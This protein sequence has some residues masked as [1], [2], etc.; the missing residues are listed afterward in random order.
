MEQNCRTRRSIGLGLTGSHGVDSGNLLRS[1]QIL[2]K[3]GREDLLM[4]VHQTLAKKDLENVVRALDKVA[5][6][7]RKV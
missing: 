4:I 6:A 1:V 2:E 3:L 7:V 5:N